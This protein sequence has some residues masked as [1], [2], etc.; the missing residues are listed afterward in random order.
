M[1]DKNE[2]RAAFSARLHEGLDEA[3]VRTRGR[4]VDIHNRLKSVG[5]HK[6]TQAISKWLNGE[7]VPESDSLAA[8]SDWLEVRREWLQYGV[9]PK[10]RVFDS[11]ANS[12]PRPATD[13]ASS[14]KGR[15]PLITWEQVKQ[16]CI[17]GIDLEALGATRW[18][19]SPVEIGRRGY[20]VTVVGDSMTNLGSGKSYPPGSII[21]VDPDQPAESGKS[22]IAQVPGTRDITFKLLAE[23][24][25][26]LYLRPANPQYPIID[27]T[28]ETHIFGTVIG[29]FIPH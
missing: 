28:D 3:G 13:E 21:Y 22:V 17:K 23:D 6:T 14:W 1:V 12:E 9:P 11:P 5:L 19:N 7:A 2:L 4:G 26:R 20:A 16:Y 24:A 27:I 8:L 15:V 10:S 29:T 18:I 25:G